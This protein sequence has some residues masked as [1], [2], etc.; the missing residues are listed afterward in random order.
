MVNIANFVIVW[1]ESSWDMMIDSAFFL[2]FGLILAGI[3]FTVLNTESIKKLL[4]GSPK[5]Q[6]FKAALLGI[7]LPLC[8]CSVLPVAYQLRKSGL[9]RSGITAFLISTPES[10]VDSILLTWSLM[11]PIMTV[12]RPLSAFLAA[13]TAGVVETAF[14]DREELMAE[15]D[16]SCGCASNGESKSSKRTSWFMKIQAGIRYGFTTLMADLAPYLALGYVMAGLVGATLGTTNLSLPEFLTSGWGSYTG[17]LILGL[18]MYICATS[19][20]PFA[21]ALIVAGFTPGAV[22]VFLLVGPATNSAS[23]IVVSRILGWWGVMRYLVV[24]IIVAVI[25]GIVIDYIYQRYEIEMNYVSLTSE[26]HTSLFSTIS[27]TILVV[28]ILWHIVVAVAKRI[29]K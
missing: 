5:L 24:I 27:A 10:G 9:H 11:D 19:S 17:A 7:P 15:V 8:S 1:A 20:T 6:V 18:P 21:T 4:T 22:L 3:V 13:T 23:I 25:S 12:A 16:S 14:D 28:L 26:H 29:R 2:L